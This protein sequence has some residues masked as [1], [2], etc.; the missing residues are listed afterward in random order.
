MR[1]CTIRQW[2]H[3]HHS[4]AHLGQL[5]EGSA[6]SPDSDRPDQA[7]STNVWIAVL[8]THAAFQD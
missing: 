5:A 4:I 3:H 2:L 7:P 1:L 8:G 6:V